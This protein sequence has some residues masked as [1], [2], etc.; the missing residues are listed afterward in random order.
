MD[1]KT[2]M[3]YMVENN[4]CIRC[5]TWEER[6]MVI[7]KILEMNSEADVYYMN[8]GYSSTTWPYALPKINPYRW[9]LCK[10]GDR[11]PITI[12]EFVDL[13]NYDDELSI[14]LEEVV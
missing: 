14:S 3:N 6:K 12:T 2:L 9:A 13:C 10:L 7:N 5:P 8:E 4:L 11:I 1:Y